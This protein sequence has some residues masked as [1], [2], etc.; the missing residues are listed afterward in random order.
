M[1]RMNG[2]NMPETLV[3]QFSSG[4]GYGRLTEQEKLEVMEENV[5]RGL[6]HLVDERNGKIEIEPRR[7][8][9]ALKSSTIGRYARR[10]RK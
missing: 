1:K 6:K 8:G 7:A 3:C 2:L 10:E 5:R 4:N 9:D